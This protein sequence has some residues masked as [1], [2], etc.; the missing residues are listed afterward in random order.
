MRN[1]SEKI[2]PNLNIAL[3]LALLVVAILNMFNP[4]MGFLYGKPAFILIAAECV[5]SVINA[6]TSYVSWRRRRA[7][8]RKYSH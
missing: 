7:A 4:M 5:V 8:Y 3:S 2:I 1:F 6:V